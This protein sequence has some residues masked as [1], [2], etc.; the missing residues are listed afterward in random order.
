MSREDSKD[1]DYFFSRK[2]SYPKKF[3]DIGAMKDL[4]NHHN[5]VQRT[6]WTDLKHVDFEKD[7][8]NELKALLGIKV[9]SRDVT[10]NMY[11]HDVKK[12]SPSGSIVVSAARLKQV[13]MIKQN[14]VANLKASVAQNGKK[15]PPI[16]KPKV[17]FQKGKG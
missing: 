1:G 6:S 16:T 13:P 8:E 12:D 2:K 11:R 14:S 10:P 9:V 15:L 4:S 5:G 3:N 17:M 7:D